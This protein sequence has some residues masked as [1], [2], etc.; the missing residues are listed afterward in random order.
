MAILFEEFNPRWNAFGGYSRYYFLIDLIE[1]AF[2]YLRATAFE[3][4]RRR[5]KHASCYMRILHIRYARWKR[6]YESLGKLFGRKGHKRVDG[7]HEILTSRWSAT[8]T[9]SA[10]GQINCNELRRER[11]SPP[12][13]AAYK[14]NVYLY[15]SNNYNLGSLGR[16]P[17]S[18]LV[19]GPAQSLSS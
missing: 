2:A 14:Q 10:R 19:P 16:D 18:Y 15:Y 8:H 3:W 12:L 4:W 13:A 17:F 9:S 1:F 7:A 11:G 6:V 5:D